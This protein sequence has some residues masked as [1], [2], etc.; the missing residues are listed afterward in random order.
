MVA[1]STKKHHDRLGH[2]YQDDNE[3]NLKKVVLET[4]E[5]VE[6]EQST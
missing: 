4:T 2:F 5:E 1:L 3:N 6:T